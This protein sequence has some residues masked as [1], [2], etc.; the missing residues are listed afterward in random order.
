MT[1]LDAWLLDI[2]AAKVA[3]KAGSM[4]PGCDYF[5]TVSSLLPASLKAVQKLG[6]GCLQLLVA[7]PLAAVPLAAG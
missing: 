2:F 6:A 4:Q 3:A 7:V 5:L 1:S